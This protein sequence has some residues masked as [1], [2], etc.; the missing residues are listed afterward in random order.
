[1]TLIMARNTFPWWEGCG[2][3]GR[4]REDRIGAAP[5][6]KTAPLGGEGTVGAWGS[7]G[8]RTLGEGVEKPDGRGGR[9][10]GILGGEATGL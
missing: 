5:P 8:G 2:Q 3:P 6:P 7:R 4:V 9:G 1:M 10:G